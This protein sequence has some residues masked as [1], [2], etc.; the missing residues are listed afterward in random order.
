MK[1]ISSS[2]SA[3]KNLSLALV[4]VLISC[5]TTS[6]SGHHGEGGKSLNGVNNEVTVKLLQTLT[7]DDNALF[8]SAMISGS[9]LLLA[10]SVSGPAREE[11]MKAVSLESKGKLFSFFKLFLSYI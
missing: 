2:S 9:L 8:S 3:Q 6:V 7:E 5:F 10:N 11:L 4:V 1:M